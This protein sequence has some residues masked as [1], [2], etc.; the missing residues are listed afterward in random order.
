[1]AMVQSTNAQKKLSPASLRDSDIEAK[2][3]LKQ[4]NPTAGEKTIPKIYDLDANMGIHKVAKKPDPNAQE[5]KI[6][7]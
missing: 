1:M 4:G 7:P 2:I 6:K 3:P 5:E